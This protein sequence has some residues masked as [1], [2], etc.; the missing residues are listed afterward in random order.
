MKL[1]SNGCCQS[2][3]Q[4]QRCGVCS[5]RVVTVSHQHTA[6]KDTCVL[7]QVHVAVQIASRVAAVAVARPHSVGV[8]IDNAQ[9]AVRGH[10][11]AND[12]TQRWIR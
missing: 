5:A 7:E 4:Q 12:R 8:L 9:H 2:T 11:A 6:K 1:Q 3:N 10:H